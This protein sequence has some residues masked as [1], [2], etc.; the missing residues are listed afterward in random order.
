M[1][2]I[3]TS[4]YYSRAIILEGGVRD[5]ARLI[6]TGAIKNEADPLQVFKDT[7]CDSLF[8]IIKC[9]DIVFRIQTVDQFSLIGSVPL[10]DDEGK[11]LA[12][13]FTAG[14][15]E[16]PIIIRVGFRWTFLTPVVGTLISPDGSGTAEIISTAVF[17]NEPYEKAIGP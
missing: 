14:A 9:E 6:R 2:I 10:F 8:G 17:R 15:S 5:A 1:G 3:E 7:L 12:A 4:L 11:P 13:E 16:S